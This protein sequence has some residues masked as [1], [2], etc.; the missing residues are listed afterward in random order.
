MKIFVLQ[1]AIDLEGTPNMLEVEIFT[2][3]FYAS[4][5]SNFSDVIIHFYTNIYHI[6]TYK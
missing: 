3:H 6:S 2:Y 4:R 5:G 1:A